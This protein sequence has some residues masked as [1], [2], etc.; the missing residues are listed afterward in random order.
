MFLYSRRVGD[1]FFSTA[2][3]HHWD[4]HAELVP[5]RTRYDGT[6]S[7]PDSTLATPILVLSN[8]YDPVT[9]LASARYAN[10]RLGDN[11]RLVVQK[12]GWGHCTSSQ[13]S[14]CTAK[15]VREFMVEGT[16]LGEKEVVCEVDQ[17][18]WKPW[19]KQDLAMSVGGGEA[20][21]MRAW[22]EL[23]EEDWGHSLP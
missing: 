6:F 23:G 13:F 18:P 15:V 14:A 11:A 3:C 20:E 7:M 1:R 4:T 16:V 22:A 12:D 17:L 2:L 9:S 19:D 5:R 10:A 8:T 21:L